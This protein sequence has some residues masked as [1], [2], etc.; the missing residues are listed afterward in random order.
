MNRAD[1]FKSY[2]SHAWHRKSFSKLSKAELELALNF[3]RENDALDA[4]S[5]ELK[6]N[7]MFIDKDKPKHFSIILELLT[8]S[9]SAFSKQ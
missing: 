6:I 7:R 4:A 2:S 8:C 9:N 1:Q 3:I 5:F